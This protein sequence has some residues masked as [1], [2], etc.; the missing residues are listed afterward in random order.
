MADR[1]SKQVRSRIMS[2]IRSSGTGPE[3]KAEKIFVEAGLSS[4]F[5]RNDPALPGKPDFSF[6]NIRRIVFID[7]AFWHGHPDHFRFGKSGKFWDEKIRKNM[8]RLT[9][10][11]SRWDMKS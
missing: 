6:S 3:R 10:N 4:L 7:G 2:K 9:G 1:F 8:E 11:L 5:I